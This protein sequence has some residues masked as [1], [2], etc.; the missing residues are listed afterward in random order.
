MLTPELERLTAGLT[1]RPGAPE[2]AVAALAAAAS[3]EGCSLPADY[4]DFMRHSNGAYGPVGQDG[5]WIRLDPVEDVLPITRG[6]RAPGGLLLLGGTRLGDA[7][8]LDIRTRTP[9]LTTVAVSWWGNWDALDPLGTTFTEALQELEHLGPLPL[10]W[11]VRADQQPDIGYVPMPHGMVRP[12][13][14]AAQVKPG[15]TV[16]DL[17]CGD[18]RIVIAA[19]RHFGARGVGFDLNVELV[20]VARAGAAAA[21][22]RHLASFQRANIFQV[23]LRPAD[24][25]TTYLLRELNLKLLPQFK[26]LKPGA[27]V[28]AYEFD[29]PGYEPVRTALAE[30]EPGV[31]GLVRV[32]EAPF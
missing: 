8:A 5:L 3:A 12:L 27:R 32:W 30:Y 29:L 13:L 20:Q 9:R 15:E 6:Q 17:G 4:L 21:G 22:V 7:L 11:A 23:D 2:A 18:G 1:K 16:Y 14:E 28:A 31:E 24:V 25:V 10:P 19:A 26:T